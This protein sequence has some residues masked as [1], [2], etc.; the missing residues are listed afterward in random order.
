MQY[1]IF[2]NLDGA[3]AQCA[4]GGVRTQLGHGLSLSRDDFRKKA[5]PYLLGPFFI[6][7]GIHFAEWARSSGAAI[8][9]AFD[10]ARALLTVSSYS[11]R[12]LESATMPAPA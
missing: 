4:H 2:S 8:A 11:K 3:R 7:L 9:R 1:S 6:L 10:I 5:P 12:G